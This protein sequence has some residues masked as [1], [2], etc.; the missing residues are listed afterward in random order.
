[1][2]FSQL[3][4]FRIRPGRYRADSL[5]SPPPGFPRNSRIFGYSSDIF[6][7]P[8]D[9]DLGER[10]D[11]LSSPRVSPVPWLGNPAHVDSF[12]TA[13]GLLCAP[14]SETRTGEFEFIHTC[15]NNGDL[16]RSPLLMFKKKYAPVVG[17][18]LICIK[19]CY[20][21]SNT[22]VIETRVQSI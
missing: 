17:N 11:T 9:Q 2:Y 21:K 4:L 14:S 7:M 5:V 22:A 3:L 18:Q 16:K 20:N 13:P 8:P 19:Q 6:N 15:H 10:S 12:S 1:M